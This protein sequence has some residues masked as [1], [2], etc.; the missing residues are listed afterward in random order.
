MSDYQA[1]VAAALATYPLI[2]SMR[3]PIVNIEV[4][5]LRNSLMLLAILV[6]MRKVIP[7]KVCPQKLNSRSLL[8]SLKSTRG[9][10]STG[11]V[12][13][14]LLTIRQILSKM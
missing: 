3:M 1:V 14:P 6:I 8:V 4:R 11:V 5:V 2:H 13:I 12:V 10:D 7:Q 9:I